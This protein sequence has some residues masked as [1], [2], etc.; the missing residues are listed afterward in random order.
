MWHS[1]ATQ[2][3]R[4]TKDA[5]HAMPTPQWHPRQDCAKDDHWR[6]AAPKGRPPSAKQSNKTNAMQRTT[7]TKC[8][9]YGT[10]VTPPSSL[11]QPECARGASTREQR[12]H[13]TFG[14]VHPPSARAGKSSTGIGGQQH[15]RGV[16]IIAVPSDECH[17]QRCCKKASTQCETSC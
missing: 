2:G 15:M 11:G 5:K 10:L 1:A 12:H 7:S 13:A 17:A 14:I 16:H 6:R 8:I 4:R 3:Q 9:M